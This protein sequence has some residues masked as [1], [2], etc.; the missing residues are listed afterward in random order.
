MIAAFPELAAAPMLW[1]ASS[2]SGVIRPDGTTT[3]LTGHRIYIPVMNSSLILEAGKAMEKR[4]W[5]EG[6]GRIKIS[7]SGNPLRRCL[8]DT[9]VYR[10]EHL[11][12]VAKPTLGPGLKREVPDPII[13]GDPNAQFDLQRV[14]DANTPD[15]AKR[16]KTNYRKQFAKKQDE[17]Q[18][19]RAAWLEKQC[20]QYEQ[21]TTMSREHVRLNLMKI[22]EDQTLPL[23]FS[24]ITAE[25][26][27]ITVSELWDDP[28]KYDKQRFHDPLE[29]DYRNDPRIAYLRMLDVKEPYIYSHA[30][31]GCRYKL[32]APRVV[33]EIVKGNVHQLKMQCMAVLS[34]SGDF[35]SYGSDKPVMAQV[36]KW[37]K[38]KVLDAMWM[39][40]ELDRRIEFRQ[41]MGS[42]SSRKSVPADTPSGV[43][44]SLL[45]NFIKFKGFPPLEAV[46]QDP[47][48][49]LDGSLL[50]TPGYDSQTKLYLVDRPGSSF[51]IPVNPSQ[52]EAA[53]CGQRA[54]GAIRRIPLVWCGRPWGSLRRRVNRLPAP[55][56]ADRAWVS[57]RCPDGGYR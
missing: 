42:G 52:E 8:I 23:F 44:A 7:I 37:G 22:F 51:S 54:V 38:L 11:D 55:D 35:F 47:I 34:K 29:P 13:V 17:I 20:K 16:A 43:S 10:P 25:G 53:D 14:I 24:L 30:H 33:V 15:V 48:L 21:K 28:K 31:G 45:T 49:R 39:T 50:N 36:M 56:F 3:G 26:E 12:F 40:D 57:F 19:I 6:L 9:C 32:E 4:L 46:I 2:S 27:E 41:V 1:C 5:A 18:R